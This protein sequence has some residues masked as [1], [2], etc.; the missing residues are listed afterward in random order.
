MSL[1]NLARGKGASQ[2]AAVVGIQNNPYP[3]TSRVVRIGL[4]NAMHFV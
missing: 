2:R 4:V 3:E 1:E